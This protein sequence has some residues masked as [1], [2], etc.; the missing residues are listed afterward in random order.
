MAKDRASLINYK[1]FLSKSEKPPIGAA[2]WKWKNIISKIEEV[3]KED[4]IS[5]GSAAVS[6][7]NNDTN[8]ALG[9]APALNA[10]VQVLEPGYHGTPHRHSNLAIFI[11][12]QGQGYSVV[13]DETIEWESGDVFFVPPWFRHEHC[14]SSD[15]ERVFLYTIQDVPTVT[16]MGTWF[17]QGSQNTG[18]EHKVTNGQK[19]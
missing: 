10:L 1:D 19:E 17:F 11:V 13:E 2:I 15:T 16:N 9:V 3:F 14:N 5:P 12:R 6:M 7:V 4:P 8:N 18:F